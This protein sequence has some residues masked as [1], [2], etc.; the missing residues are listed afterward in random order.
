MRIELTMT[1]RTTILCLMLTLGAVAQNFDVGDTSSG[2][3][4]IRIRDLGELP[5]QYKEF[6]RDKRLI[7]ALEALPEGHTLQVTFDS[8]NAA[9][10]PGQ[11][12]VYVGGVTP[13]NAEGKPDGE[14]MGWT[15]HGGKM[16]RK[17]LWKNGVKDGVE[18]LYATSTE[19][20]WVVGVI[21]GEKKTFHP[22]G[23][24]STISPYVDNAVH[25]LAKSWDE[26]GHL[27]R[28]AGFEHGDRHGESIDY[29]PGT[30]QPSKIIPYEHGAVH[31]LCRAYYLNGKLKW[32]RPFVDNRPHGVE[33]HYDVEGQVEKERHYL[34]GEAVTP[35][36]YA[37]A[38]A[39]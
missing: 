30:E 17:T 38:T 22:N 23:E 14:E 2:R 18:H 6:A 19:I 24:V 5:A 31:G 16:V 33:R 4:A 27:I 13:L 7:A 20:P 26:E 25:G 37:A 28:V 3:Q 11:I 10:G 21:Q 29:W 15:F 9:G 34:Q 12:K 32:E 35:E 39:D 36:E 8:F 1:A